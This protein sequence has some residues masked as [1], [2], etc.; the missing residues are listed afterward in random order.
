VG[1]AP[2]LPRRSTERA[3]APSQSVSGQLQASATPWR[4]KTPTSRRPPSQ[5]EVRLEIV[6]FVRLRVSGSPISALIVVVLVLA[7]V[8]VLGLAGRL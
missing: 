1:R 5:L 2:A 4:M 8:M 7:V 6:K 3:L